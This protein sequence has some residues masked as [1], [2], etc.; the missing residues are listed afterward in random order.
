MT[1]VKTISHDELLAM[2]HQHISVFTAK[3]SAG[4]IIDNLN[5]ALIYCFI[6]GFKAANP[7]SRLVVPGFN[8]E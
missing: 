3:Y 4:H 6:E 8:F 1:I 5:N 7:P 2:A